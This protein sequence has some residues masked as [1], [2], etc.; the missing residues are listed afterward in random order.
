MQG[1]E[2]ELE[3]NRQGTLD[4][5]GLREVIAA[6]RNL[7]AGRELAEQVRLRVIPERPDRLTVTAHRARV[8][9]DAV[10]FTLHRECG[11]AIRPTRNER[12]DGGSDS[13]NLTAV[14]DERRT[15]QQTDDDPVVR[16]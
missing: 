2:N 7:R 12:L 10:F 13:P 16:H 8:D 4:E 14:R 5:S 3:D 11:D 9:A 6:H 15:S 1:A